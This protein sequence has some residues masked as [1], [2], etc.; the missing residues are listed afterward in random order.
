MEEEN[1]LDFDTWLNN[2][3]VF[4]SLCDRFNNTIKYVDD[5]LDS[6]GD[7]INGN[8][9]SNEYASILFLAASEFESIAKQLC[10]NY[11]QSFNTQTATIKN[12][13]E[14]ILLAFPNIGNA[15]I[16]LPHKPITPLSN[17][18]INQTNN[19]IVGLNWWDD[20]NDLKHDRYTHF[21]KANLHNCIY[22]L[23]SLL[24]LELYMA[25][26]LQNDYD[27]LPNDQ[28]NYLKSP[29]HILFMYPCSYFS[30]KYIRGLTLLP[31]D[32]LP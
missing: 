4:C 20:H 9:F 13:T 12:M 29:R 24:L 30:F 21:Y 3:R 26:E 16:D 22:V 14:T 19:K 11:D 1:M 5:K 15:N 18:G 23:S 31:A 17:W 8:T 10:S 25:Q 7:Y 6:N 28:R 2:W 32:Q 27:K